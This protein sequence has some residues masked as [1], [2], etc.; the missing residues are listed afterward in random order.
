[1]PGKLMSRDTKAQRRYRLVEQVRARGFS[2]EETEALLRIERTLS[3]W[4]EL[5]C[6]T[7]NDH[8]TLL[9]ERDEE[10]GKPFLRRQWADWD[11][12]WHD[13]KRPYPDKEKHAIARLGKIM[14]SHPNFVAYHQGDPRGCCLY[15]V[16][17]AELEGG[18]INSLYTRGLAIT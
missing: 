14:A 16:R 18:D 5:E 7:G 2:F 8:V 12:K 13:T 6:G 3:K 4:G 10:T 9:V 15:I 17:K 11:G 1:M